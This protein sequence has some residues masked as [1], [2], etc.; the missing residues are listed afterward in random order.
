MNSARV[1]HTLTMLADGTRAGRRRGVHERPDAASPRA[2]CR[3]RSGTRR[4]RRGPRSPRCPP[5]ATTTRRPCS[6]PTARCWSPVADMG[7]ATRRRPGSTRPRSTRRRT[8]P[9]ARARR[10]RLRRRP[11]PTARPCR[12]ARRTRPSISAVNLVSLGADTHQSDMTQHFVP[13]SFT[14]GSGSL[15]CSG[16][17]IGRHSPR[18]ATYMVFISTG[19]ACPP[20]PRSSS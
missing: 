3:R 6:C 15:N 18:R 10:S 20:S 12:S 5:P 14:A 16:T 11:R 2:C 13:L 7:R 19:P 17:R 4:P 9:T 8:C 1:Y